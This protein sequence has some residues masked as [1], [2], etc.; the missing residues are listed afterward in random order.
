MC[1]FSAFKYICLFCLNTVLSCKPSLYPTVFERLY[2]RYVCLCING[3]NRDTSIKYI[4]TSPTEMNSWAQQHSRLLK[5]GFCVGMV[6]I[7]YL[8]PKNET[9]LPEVVTV[10]L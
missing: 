7:K 10:L 2:Q 1:T 4:M 3:L 9:C 8:Q 5:L 6:R